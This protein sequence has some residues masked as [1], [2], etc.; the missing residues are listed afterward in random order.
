MQSD[1]EG[2]PGGESTGRLL[3]RID[4]G[5]DEA[6]E[7]L[8]AV[9][10]E[11]LRRAAGRWMGDERTAHTLQPTA[12]VHEAFVRLV[13]SGPSADW[14]SRRHF[15]RVAA[16]AMR[17]VLVDHARARKAQK[18]GGELERHGLDQ[19][20]EGFREERIDLLELDEAVERLARM[21]EK[22]ARI[23]EL[24][25]FGGLTVEEVAPI[26]GVSTPTVQRGWRLARMW[27]RKELA[28]E[29][30]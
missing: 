23:V 1:G 20:L 29:S 17:N 21:D 15:F 7:E 26:L 12:L 16:R 9:L 24:R 3:R 30:D 28:P 8:F 18:R 6:A 14:E 27:L 13:D 4:G 22:L 5:D 19:V 2:T 11:D 10:Y 25:F